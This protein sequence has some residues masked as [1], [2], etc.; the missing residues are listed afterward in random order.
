MPP[1][2]TGAADSSTAWCG[3]PGAAQVER[4]HLNLHGRP[5]SYLEAGEDTGGPI[6]VLIHGLAGDATHWRDVIAGLGRHTH[7]LAPDLLGHGA[8]AT[9]PN[10]DYTVS[11]HA[12]RLRDLLRCL[13][14]QQVS[15][16]GH[17]FGGGVAMAFAYQ[18]P[19]RTETL[20]L[21]SSGG[22]GP[23]LSIALRTACL[24]GILR[25]AHT[26][27]K[28]TPPWVARLAQHSATALGLAR[29]TDLDEL[30]HVLR[31]LQD[32]ANRQAFLCTLRGVASW[33]GQRLDATDRLYLLAELPILLITGRR[34]GCIP[35]QH[36]LRAHQLL[37]GSRL[38][39]LDAGHFPHT[40]HPEKVT[41]LILELLSR[42]EHCSIQSRDR[43]AS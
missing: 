42:S 34:D 27:N 38:E 28:L 14:H 43:S 10:A 18:F 22:L 5:M 24:P 8:S 39:L 40:E 36:T 11:A 30:G 2:V 25:A 15:L 17:S 3:E 20:T 31:A 19:E 13:G 4:H 26:L 41:A 35:Y 9:P 12:S 6:L 1:I 32:L 7:I 21:I 33:S 23:E 16:V 37:P 29:G